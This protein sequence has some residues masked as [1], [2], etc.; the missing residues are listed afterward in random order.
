ML[1]YPNKTTAPPEINNHRGPFENKEAEVPTPFI[2]DPSN[3][4][5]Y[6]G[7]LRFKIE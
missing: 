6:D 1:P 4:E 7:T 3:Y 2:N 5:T